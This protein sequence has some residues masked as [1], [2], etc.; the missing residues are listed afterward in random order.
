MIGKLKGQIDLIGNGYIIVDVSGVGYKVAVSSSLLAD[1]KMG[2]EITLFIH[3]HVREDH[4]SLFGFLTNEELVFFEM[5]IGV[6][7][8]GPKAALNIL[9]ATPIE[10]IQT[11]ISKQDPSL[12]NTVSGIGKKTAE[13]I[14]IELKNKIGI[15]AEGNIFEKSAETDEVVSAL[16]GLGYKAAEVRAVLPK[17]TGE[18]T[19]SRIKEALKLLSK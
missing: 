10:K 18:D 9:S 1:S 17:V 11:A 2:D 13:K 16:E 14:V 8:V 15:I 12:L 7:G 5:L 19:E 3:T 4:L 6:S